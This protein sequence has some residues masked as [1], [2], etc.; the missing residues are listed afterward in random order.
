MWTVNYHAVVV[1]WTIYT[2][3]EVAR[4]GLVTAMVM[5][6]IMIAVIAG[7]IS[8]VIMVSAV[9]VSAWTVAAIVVAAVVSIA[10]VVISVFLARI[11]SSTYSVATRLRR[12]LVATVVAV[13]V[14]CG[15]ISI[16]LGPVACFGSI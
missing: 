5:V 7:A 9:V 15:V 16:G 4:T 3:V 6:T 8:S 1:V 10:V 13:G 2:R 14:D 12:A 11:E